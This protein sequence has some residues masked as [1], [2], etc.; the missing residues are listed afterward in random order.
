MKTIELLKISMN[1]LCV[2]TENNI[3][4]DDWQYIDVYEQ[5][6]NMRRNRVKHTAAIDELSSDI[7][8]SPRTLERAFKRLGSE[9][10]EFNI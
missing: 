3:L 8:V 7:G 6:I 1:M 2:M 5:Y 9:C 4:R 10:K